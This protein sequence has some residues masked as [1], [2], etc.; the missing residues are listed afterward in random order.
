MKSI[1]AEKGQYIIIIIIIHGQINTYINDKWKLTT[2][3][4]LIHIFL[5]F[6]NFFLMENPDG[7]QSI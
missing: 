7:I 1:N 2:E 3:N 5:K 4:W 6:G